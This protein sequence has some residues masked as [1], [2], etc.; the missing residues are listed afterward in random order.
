MAF[1]IGLAIGLIAGPAVSCPAGADA[2]PATRDVIPAGPMGVSEPD[3]LAWRTWPAPPAAPMP[4]VAGVP[5]ATAAPRHQPDARPVAVRKAPRQP[6]TA[7]SG[8]ASYVGASYGADYLAARLRKGTRLRVC[9]PVGC[10]TGTVN[11]YGPSRRIFPGR[12]VDLSAARFERVC[13][14]LS[15]GTCAV[16]VARA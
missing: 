10:I 5:P 9:G 6:R 4:S 15:M 12:I 14:R 3:R 7:R 1:A 2:R 8:L 16:T 11:D 13:G